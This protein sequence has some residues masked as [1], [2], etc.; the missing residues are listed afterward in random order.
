MN[1]KP[2]LPKA[3]D[4]KPVEDKWAHFWIEEGLFKADAGSSK[5]KFSMVL[6]PPNVT[7]SLHMGHALCFTLPDIIARWK[8]MLGYNVLW[9][10]GTDHASIAVHNVIEQELQK[11]GLSRKDLSRDEFLKIAWEWKEK[12]GGV[13]TNQLKKMG[14]SL[15]WSRE[16]FTM[17]EGFSRAVR[18]VFVN[19]Y[20]EGLI[21][22]DYY[23]VNH[24]PRCGTVLSD[25]EVE[26][27]ELSAKLYYIR[28][29]LVDGQGGVV[30]ATTRPE[31][32]LGD[33]A[34]AVNPDD[35]R[36]KHLVGKKV[37]LPLQNHPIPIIAD[38]SVEMDFGTGAVKVTPAHDP[39]DFQLG[40][41]HKL[42]QIIVIDSQG[43]MTAEAGQEFQGLDRFECRQK[44]LEK[45]RD[46]GLLIK[47]E[48][49]RHAVGHCYRCK[50]VIEPHLSWQWFVKIGPL[51]REAIRVV[52]EGRIRFIPPN[53]AK[54]Y[55]EWMYNI[56]DWCISRQLWWG[57][58]IPAWYCQDCQEVMVEMEA[59]QE[60]SR[61]HSRRLVQD[62][63]ILDTWFSSALWPFGTM[64]WPEEAEDLRVF[65]P[66][67]LMATGFD[68]IFFW[69][70][71]MIMMGLKF[72]GD[73]PFRDVF[74]N[75]LVRDFK[76][77]K[78]SKS[79]GNIID[80]LEMTEK[81]GTD[82]LRFTLAALAIPGMDIS[83]SEERM[84]GYRAFVNKIWN[85]ARFVFLNLEEKSGERGELTLADRWIRSRLSRV[86]RE[87]NTSLEAYKFY[88]AANRIYHFVWHEFCDWYLE[89]VKPALERGN[90]KSR[91][92]L[93][94][95]LDMI[96]RLLHP[97]MPFVTEEIWQH[98]PGSGRSLLE[99]SF[100]Q[101]EP[102]WLDEAAEEQLAR[103]QELITAVRTIK[104]ENTIP[105]KKKVSLWVKITH[106]ADKDF[107]EAHQA[108]IFHLAQLKDMRLVDDF[109]AAEKFLKGLAGDWEVGLL[110]EEG[111]I[112]LEKEI[113]RLE[114]ELK[115]T[116]EDIAKL[117][118]RLNQKSFL[119]K[120]PREVVGETRSR[121]EE[122]QRKR[123]KTREHLTALQALS[124]SE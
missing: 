65:Y 6:P 54:T 57:H 109:P 7:G 107:L 5:P 2:K 101:Y 41:K 66:T 29:P 118:A 106:S 86:A 52:E 50:T 13:I 61:C 80:P 71:R 104:A 102:E 4:P 44:V 103:L 31:T 63:D 19:L 26:H 55:F 92:T 81:Y 75:G 36:Y 3:Y 100:P 47:E 98:L 95:M 53:W 67:D 110:V 42:D 84:A 116:E 14:F 34:V 121:L 20:K 76:K 73:I 27:K 12:Y 87:M 88:E 15:D 96:L 8:R 70:A 1:K 30:V 77:R 24:C 74:I 28:Y 78:M 25:I 21:Y 111:L 90:E 9:L 89:L 115:K 17:D 94:E 64:G 38:E 23:L 83:L 11:K 120:A 18:T 99:A 10:P 123:E 119:E 68:I 43:R 105:L 122:L 69:V 60:C 37:I 124:T 56:H 35:K 72:M 112:E 32:M 51:A 117:E 46:E 114:R 79:E 91:E 33:T 59:P 58:R 97:F 113:N 39:T 45:L 82:A 22:R 16:R 108:E 62:E 40:K 48:D 85:A 49:Y 93:V